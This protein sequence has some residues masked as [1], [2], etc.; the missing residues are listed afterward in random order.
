MPKYDQ[1]VLNTFVKGL[2]TEAG[3]MTFPDSASVDELNCDLFRD[4]T[5]RRRK[6][7]NREANFQASTFN[8]TNTL[9]MTTGS[10]INVGDVGNK[11]YLVVQAGSVLYF[12]NKGLL[13]YSGQEVATSIDLITYQVAGTIGVDQAKC[14]FASIGGSL[15]VV[16]EAME[17]V[18][19]TE[20]AGVI[21][22]TQIT[23]RIRDFEWL[24]E[25]NSYNTS[26]AT[27]SATSARKYDTA[28]S[29]WVGT[30]GAAALATYIAARS[31]YPPLSLP[32][33][34]GKDSN[35][36]FSVTEWEEIYTGSSLLGNG[37]FILDL[38]SKD[39]TTASGVAGITTELEN[40]RFTTV[41]AFSGRVFYAGLS[42]QK[43]SGRLFF[44]RIIENA[45]EYG[46]CSQQND[47]TSETISDILETDGGVIN[48][49]G[50][51]A[52]RKLYA[53]KNSLF[54]FS[55]SGVWEISGADDIFS[56][57]S[58]TVSRISS[59]G[60]Q[61]PTSFVS[62]EGTP[63]WWS[64]YGIHTLSFNEFGKATEQNISITT[65]QSFWDTLD[66]TAKDAVEGVYDPINKKIY[67]SYP[68]NNEAVRNK[69]NNIIVLDIQLQAFYPWR[70]VDEASNT[71]YMCG[72]T[73]YSGFGS[74]TATL[75]VITSA[76]DDVVTSAGDDVQSTQDS[77]LTNENT[78]IVFLIKDY[79]SGKMTMGFVSD[80]TFLDWGT[81]NYSSYAETGYDFL[82]DAVIKKTAPYLVSYLR[83]TETGWTG[84]ETIGY[85]PIGD[86]SIKVSS[87]WDFKKTPS[88]APQ[89]AYRR[90]LPLVVDTDDLTAF[91][92]PHT[93]L[94][95]RLKMRGRGRSM[96]VR[97]ESEQG[98]DF[99]L[100]GHAII[101]AASDRF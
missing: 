53:F 36:N 84:N 7:I 80:T 31:A 62:A 42:S 99:V 1:K 94:S 82:G 56:P 3:E 8:I 52:V 59:I 21:T 39:R 13:P 92:S 96:R 12:F 5:R 72:L 98:K 97:Y 49:P 33:Y 46:D 19:L 100:I 17:P 43:N 30:K 34:S 16:S 11:E 23:P 15:L 20:L 37:H 90:Q 9:T 6:G 101:T 60:M 44:S 76:G 10:W 69:K 87:Y 40:S 38:F 18:Y 61:S 29:G 26:I 79:T 91:N 71:D 67:W 48:I 78:A 75:D 89:Q 4:A 24:G 51:T 57:T 54:I 65:I 25:K 95:S 45:N 35:G 88:S 28:N 32:W 68:D 55:E 81:T 85:T 77:S 83:E 93:V 73:F 50:L 74:D 58:Y 64:R 14:Q 41:A 70:F 66:T 22:A 27:G 63:F 47:P 86:S 2:I